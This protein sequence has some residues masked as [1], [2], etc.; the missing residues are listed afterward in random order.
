[1]K[2]RRSRRSSSSSQEGGASSPKRRMMEKDVPV[3][4]ETLFFQR[5]LGEGSYGQVLQAT[6][7]ATGREYAIKV[8]K[9]RTLV[10]RGGMKRVILE[11]RILR[12]ASGC[13]FL[14]QGRFALQTPDL[15]MMGMDLA[16]GGDLHDL[17]RN[18]G[19]LDISTVKFYAAEIVCALQYLHS[20]GYIHR[21]LKPA[22]ILL[23]GT[24]HIKLADFGL[25]MEG[26][27]SR[28]CVGT[29]DYMAPEMRQRLEYDAAVDWYSF[30]VVLYEMLLWADP[31]VRLGANGDIR[32]HAFF[33]GINWVALEG[34]HM[35]PPIIPEQPPETANL[36]HR[37][38]QEMMTAIGE[39]QMDPT[40]PED[41]QLLQVFSFQGREGQSRLVD[42]DC[43]NLKALEPWQE[44]RLWHMR[45]CVVKLARCD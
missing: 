22:N 45:T 17:L 33:R 16:R 37:T 1:M 20:K 42:P 32:R 35:V 18:R 8:I 43:W 28:I 14:I 34:L 30:G 12:S 6:H 11:S 36:P 2:R 39:D 26:T 4:L 44:R 15:L 9:K 41:Q 19:P 29:R 31:R 23:D 5:W 21:D 27:A 7:S 3:S 25:A 38:L 24:G 40:G 10:S 13:P